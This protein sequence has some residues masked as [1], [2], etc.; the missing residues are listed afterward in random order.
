MLTRYNAEP[1]LV[2]VDQEA[3]TLTGCNAVT[4]ESR[5]TKS[6]DAKYLLSDEISLVDN[7]LR[8]FYSLISPP[9]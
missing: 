8:Y 5:A 3:T 4:G 2:P 7:D 6:R 9:A 1:V